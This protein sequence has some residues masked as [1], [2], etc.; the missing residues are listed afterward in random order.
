MHYVPAEPLLSPSLLAKALRRSPEAPAQGMRFFSHAR[1]ALARYVV[2]QGITEGILYVPSYICT[3]AVEPLERLGQ[4]ICYYPVLESLEPDWDWISREPNPAGKALLLVHYFGFPNAIE[5][6]LEF[7]QARGLLLVE[8]CAHAFLTRVRGRAVGTFG[9]AGFYS[10][11][12]FLPLPDG[13]ALVMKNQSQTARSPAAPASLARTRY[14]P[15][16]RQLLKFGV[17]KT[18]VPTPL[19]RWWRDRRLMPPPDGRGGD[20]LGPATDS[21]SEL[22]YRIVT[23]LALEFDGMVLRRRENYQRLAEAFSSFPEVKLVYPRL[24]EGVCPYL[25]PVLVQGRDRI[26]ADLRRGGIPAQGWPVLPAAVQLDPTFNLAHY[27]SRQL[28]TLPVHQDLRVSCMDR[29]IG[30]YRRVR[31]SVAERTRAV[32]PDQSG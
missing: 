12:K 9:D 29:I 32:G 15:V 8:D 24:T 26:I 7:C 14:G 2:E 25:F 16:A 31:I 1:H 23:H 22:S 13:A 11:R 10:L 5:E 30:S 20:L 18:G 27:Y 3:E 6:A 17:A 19:W 21:M 4:R 28:L